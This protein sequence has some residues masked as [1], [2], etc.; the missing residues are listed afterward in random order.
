ME[1][2]KNIISIRE[3]SGLKQSEI[4]LRLGIDQPNYSR[5]E[6]RGDKLSIEQIKAI[7]LAL[8]V[9]VSELLGFDDPVESE[10]KIKEMEI[11]LRELKN[12]SRRIEMLLD[13]THI[14]LNDT[15]SRYVNKIAE[16]KGIKVRYKVL[17][18]FENSKDL[19][20]MG[21]YDNM[22]S[23]PDIVSQLEKERGQIIRVETHSSIFDID[24]EKIYR[25]MATDMT[26]KEAFKVL[27]GSQMVDDELAMSFY[28]DLI[29]GGSNS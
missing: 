23:F 8:E 28:I 12:N 2:T 29:H 19:E 7:A 25:F 5:L 14:Y 16:E 24:K 6:K 10:A 18:Q 11:E 1:V 20:F 17:V 9:P 26:Y 27:I 22:D 13:T 15:L 21:Y 4:A 3:S